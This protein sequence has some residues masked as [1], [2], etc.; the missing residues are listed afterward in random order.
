MKFVLICFLSLLAGSAAAA[1]LTRDG[2][3]AFDA[4]KGASLFRFGNG[5]APGMSPSER[6]VQ[7]LLIETNSL[8][9]FQNLIE[10]ASIPGQLYALTVQRQFDNENFQKNIKAF[11]ASTNTVEIMEGCLLRSA[12][13]GEIADQIRA[14]RYSVWSR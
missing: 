9:L 11:Q 14:G 7:V 6:S 4:L 2:E 12:C 13:V 1:N 5:R 3:Q 8:A 10:E